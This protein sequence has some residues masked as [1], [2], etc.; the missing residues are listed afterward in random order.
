MF[1]QVI[2]GKC[3]RRNDMRAAIEEWRDERAP[4]VVGWLGGTYGFTD[5]DVFVAVVQFGSSEDARQNTETREHSDW[6]ART[7]RLFDGDPVFHNCSHVALAVDEGFEEARFVQVIQGRADDPD[8]LEAMAAEMQEI[9]TERPEIIGATLAVD[10]SGTF[11][12]T[13][14]FT[15]EASARH[16]ENPPAPAADGVRRL[17]LRQPWFAN[18]WG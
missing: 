1:I 10:E 8:H 9:L 12:Q 18:R 17:D 2:Q 16:G 5:D 3:Y 6:W 13:V 4:D 7:R 15:N 14:A 11:T